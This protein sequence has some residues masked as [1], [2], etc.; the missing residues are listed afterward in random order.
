M[1]AGSKNSVQI[2]NCRQKVSEHVVKN[3]WWMS[4]KNQKI[5]YSYK[6]CED[7]PLSMS[8]GLEPSYRRFGAC[9]QLF[10]TPA[11]KKDTCYSILQHCKA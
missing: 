7:R 5:L 2:I 9:E 11:M 8:Q 10:F 4:A 3:Y 1:E 6:L